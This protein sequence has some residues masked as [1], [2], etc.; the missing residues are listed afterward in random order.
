MIGLN[1]LVIAC[2]QSDIKSVEEA[3]TAEGVQ[4]GS[5]IC[6]SSSSSSSSVTSSSSGN[7]C[8]P[9]GSETGTGIGSETGVPFTCTLDTASAS[10]LAKLY[11]DPP[12]SLVKGDTITIGVKANGRLAASDQFIAP[13]DKTPKVVV[14]HAGGTVEATIPSYQTHGSFSVL[15]YPFGNLPVGEVCIKVMMGTRVELAQKVSVAA[16]Q[17]ISAALGA[18]KVVAGKN[19]QKTCSERSDGETI[20]TVEVVDAND[21]PIPNLPLKI[22]NSGFVEGDK[23]HGNGDTEDIQTDIIANNELKTDGNGRLSRALKSPVSGGNGYPSAGMNFLTIAVGD[24]RPSDIAIGISTG[25]WESFRQAIGGSVENFSCGN[26]GNVWGHWSHI[27]RFKWDPNAQT[28]C[29]EHNDLA[30]LNGK[31]NKPLSAPSNPTPCWNFGP[32]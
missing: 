3:G 6:S 27:V 15:Y 8:D 24:G 14:T 23:F 32:Y 29:R 1:I 25:W 4:T 11:L 12:A 2:S 16:Y 19:H 10:E 9:T 21:N 7:S 18:Y 22:G 17:N 30:G 20:L 26:G 31:I 28:F 13:A 5:N